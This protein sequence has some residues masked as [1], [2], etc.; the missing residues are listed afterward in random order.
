[1]ARLVPAAGVVKER[2]S[3]L[4]V[5]KLPVVLSP[6]APRPVAVLQSPCGVV[7]KGEHSTGRVVRA[8]SVVQ[9]RAGAGCCVGVCGVGKER[10]STHGRIE[11]ADFVAVDREPTNYCIVCSAREIKKCVLPLCGVAAWITATRWRIDSLRRG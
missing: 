6:S 11:A 3:V 4:A 2:V 1:M 8:C 7:K 10:T 5:L 9:K